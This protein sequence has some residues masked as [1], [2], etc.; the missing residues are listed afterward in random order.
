MD[1]EASSSQSSS[2]QDFFDDK[3]I[4]LEVKKSSPRAVLRQIQLMLDVEKSL[5]FQAPVS[6]KDYLSLLI[7]GYIVS[8]NSLCTNPIQCKLSIITE[9]C[10]VSI[11]VNYNKWIPE[12]TVLPSISFD[13]Y[14]YIPKDLLKHLKSS[15]NGNT[16]IHITA[17]PFLIGGIIPDVIFAFTSNLNKQYIPSNLYNIVFQNKRHLY[18]KANKD[19]SSK[20]KLE[21]SQ[22]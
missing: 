18:A 15:K 3:Y 12:R 11:D 5:I 10:D 1:Y 9:T 4:R 14:I 7:V 20:R 16:V 17:F 6:R 19:E 22:E 8:I 21:E 2:Q 13:N